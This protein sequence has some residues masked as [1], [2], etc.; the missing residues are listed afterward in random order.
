MNQE[1]KEKWVKALRSGY[2]E[3]CKEFLSIDNRFCCLGV[4]CEIAVREGITSKKESGVSYVKYYDDDIKTI[5]PSVRGWA[6][7]PINPI[8]KYGGGK[9]YITELNDGYCLNFNEIA[10]LIEEQL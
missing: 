3:Q 1:V 8:I 7:L 9:V 6:E 2:Y 5:P 10:N 4:L